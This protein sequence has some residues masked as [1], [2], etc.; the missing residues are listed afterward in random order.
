MQ[1]DERLVVAGHS[2]QAC[3]LSAQ[4]TVSPLRDI[5]VAFVLMSKVVVA[6]V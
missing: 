6:E 2:L 1:G 5:R 4:D 3:G